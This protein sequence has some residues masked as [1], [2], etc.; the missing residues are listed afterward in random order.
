MYKAN[1]P[2]LVLLILI[3]CCH[4]AL[5]F[6][7]SPIKGMGDL[8]NGILHPLLVPAQL[9]VVVGFGLLLGQQ[10]PVRQI[11]IVWI[12]ALT[13]LASVI[14]S[15]LKPD[16]L[17]LPQSWLLLLSLIICALILL[18]IKK[19][20]FHFMVLIAI[21]SAI[22]SIL[23]VA[24]DLLSLQASITLLFGNV[25]GIYLILLYAMAL[26]ESLSHKAYQ[27]MMVRILASWIS[28]AALMVWALAFG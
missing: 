5:V 9:L 12:F 3:G 1:T 16:F 27:Q 7:H 23:F 26:S 28:A 18:P 8:F 19:I 11:T 20:P 6:A 22:F 25:C 2:C 13:L 15:W 4:P 14:G 10:Q 17:P 21:G 24:H